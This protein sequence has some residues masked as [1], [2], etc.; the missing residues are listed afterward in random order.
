MPRSGSSKNRPR[1]RKASWR[2][3]KSKGSDSVLRK[4]RK[5]GL[6]RVRPH[7]RHL[8]RTESDPLLLDLRQLAFLVLGRFFDDPLRGIAR[9]LLVAGEAPDE[10]AATVR[11]RVQVR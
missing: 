1:T 5:W 3:S 2:R 11:H 9:H 4:W 6:T 7:L 10:R 8:R